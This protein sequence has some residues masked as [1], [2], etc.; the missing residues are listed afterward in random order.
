MKKF[1]PR[2][3]FLLGLLL[4]LMA[5]SSLA[6]SE[7]GPVKVGLYYGS[8][9]LASA[10]LEN[11]VGSGYRFGYYNNG[12]FVTLGSTSVTQIS[13]LKTQNIYLAGEHGKDVPAGAGVVLKKNFGGLGLSHGNAR[14]GGA[15]N[16]AA[17][18]PQGIHSRLGRL[19]GGIS[20]A[21]DIVCT[22]RPRGEA[23]GQCGR[24]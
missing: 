18:D 5:G 23:A 15:H 11:S 10:N 4:A 1:F 21:S 12:S 20:A 6:V 22:G 8:S 7:Q 16:R 3:A 2:F 17:G 14:R 19:S 9:A 13:M 24:L